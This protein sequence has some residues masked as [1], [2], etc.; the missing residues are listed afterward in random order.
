MKLYRIMDDGAAFLLF[1]NIKPADSFFRKLFGLVFS[2]P[3]KENEGLLIEEC[4]SV[5]TFWMRY[6]IDILFLDSS[7]RVLKFFESLRPFRVTPFIRG[8]VKTV[9]LKSGTLKASQIKA[10]DC[11]KLA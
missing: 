2:P 7:N 9:E 3:L 5:H 10:G 4:N 6:P 1:T 8:A 11:L